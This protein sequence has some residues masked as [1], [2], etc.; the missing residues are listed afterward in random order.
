[1]AN[2]DD[3]DRIFMGA[4]RFKNTV[5]AI[6]RETENGIDSPRTKSPD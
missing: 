5:N 6:T 4:E 3:L 1:M 2:L